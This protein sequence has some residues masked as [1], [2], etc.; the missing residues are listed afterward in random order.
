MI[1]SVLGLT[2]PRRIL[3]CLLACFLLAVPSL[4]EEERVT[5]ADM[6]KVLKW[7]GTCVGEGENRG[8]CATFVQACTGLPLTKY[9]KRG[10]KVEGSTSLVKGTPIATFDE[11]GKY[12]TGAVKK[13]AAIYDHTD[14][15]GVVWVWHQYAKGRRP[16]EVHLAPLTSGGISVGQYYV[17][18]TARAEKDKGTAGSRASLEGTTWIREGWQG[19]GYKETIRFGKDGRG[20]M[21]IQQEGKQDFTGPIRWKEE[22]GKLSWAWESNP[23]NV[24]QLGTVEGNTMKWDKDRPGSWFKKKPAD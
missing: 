14:S 7:K 8:Q 10:A 2:L 11:T 5:L 6:A 20:T 15:N 3:A 4:S 17:V 12:P 1:V 13:H 19:R 21:T 22:R 23:R 24:T 18:R 16:N 9:W